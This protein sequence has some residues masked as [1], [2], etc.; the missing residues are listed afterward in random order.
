VRG[1]LKSVLVCAA[2]IVFAAVATACSPQAP[3]SFNSVDITG[4]GYAGNLA[5]LADVDGR[6]RTL[7]DF[8]GKVTVV[9]FGFTHCPDVCPTTLAELAEI[10]RSLGKDG[11][12]LQGVLVTV[13]PERDTPE[14]LKAYVSK[15]D[16]SFVALR[17]SV[18]QTRST[19][20]EFKVFFAKVPS[21]DGT[22]YS[23]DHT[24]GSYVFDTQGRVRLFTRYGSDT[25][26]LLEDIK[27][28][29]AEG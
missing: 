17:G 24:A 19:A 2:W 7:A 27:R 3:R 5:T 18:E 1:E 16:P 15:F 26:A 29:L 23:M 22:T 10:K 11:E 8:R 25:R 28:L 14:V 9:F 4:A 12:R 20:T 13:D 6:P 21:K